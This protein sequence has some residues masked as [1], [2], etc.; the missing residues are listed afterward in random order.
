MFE[1]FVGFQRFAT[2]IKQ[3]TS[4]DNKQNVGKKDVIDFVQ[5]KC[6]YKIKVSVFL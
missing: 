4:I 3:L 5:F 6:A 2:I 1:F